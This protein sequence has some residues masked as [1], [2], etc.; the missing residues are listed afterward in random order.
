M[1]YIPFVLGGMFAW[2]FTGSW[3]AGV[4]GTL[5]GIAIM[6]VISRLV[7]GKWRLP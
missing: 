1:V 3:I 6:R 5:G 2:A 4:G 7:T